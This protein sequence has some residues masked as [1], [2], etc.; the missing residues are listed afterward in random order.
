[1]TTINGELVMLA[2]VSKTQEPKVR[3]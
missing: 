2:S 1:L 3:T